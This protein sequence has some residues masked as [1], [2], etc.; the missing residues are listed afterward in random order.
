MQA[1]N[2]QFSV[3]KGLPFPE[4]K[5]AVWEKIKDLPYPTKRITASDDRVM[6]MLESLAD[7]RPMI[8]KRKFRVNLVVKKT[9]YFDEFYGRQWD[10]MVMVSEKGAYDKYNVVADMFNELPRIKS[11]GIAAPFSSFEAWSNQEYSTVWIQR[12]HTD[13]ITS[14]SAHILREYLYESVPEPRQGYPSDYV[15]LYSLTQGPILD[16][17]SAYGDRMIVAL[18]KR[19][20]YV[21]IDPWKDLFRGYADILKFTEK[22]YPSSREGIEMIRGCSENFI[23]RSKQFG[24]VISSP[25]PYDV[26]PYGM[27]SEENREGQSYETYPDLVSW[28]VN[29][30][31]ATIETAYLCLKEGGVY[32]ATLL[33][34]IKGKSRQG[35]SEDFKEIIYTELFLLICSA[36]G[37]RYKG[38][39]GHEGGQGSITPWW[40]FQRGELDT[41]E[42]RRAINSIQ[43]HY[44]LVYERIIPRL[45]VYLGSPVLIPVREN[46]YEG[47]DMSF[48]FLV[49]DLPPFYRSPA[50]EF[51]RAEVMDMVLHSIS[52]TLRQVADIPRDKIV[53]YTSD[54]I[55]AQRLAVD[56]LFPFSGNFID[57]FVGS[58]SW[59]T[60]ISPE[61]Y[62]DILTSGR[63]I[64]GGRAFKGVPALM[65]AGISLASKFACRP[66][67]VTYSISEEGNISTITFNKE[68]TEPRKITLAT[69]ALDRLRSRYKGGSFDLDASI[70]LLRYASLG[71]TTHNFTRDSLR[72]EEL[73]KIT[74]CDFEPFASPFNA[75]SRF[76]CS[77]F[78]DTDAP[79]GSQG[80]FFSGELISGVYSINPANDPEI[81]KLA[82]ERSIKLVEEA[83]KEEE[84]LMLLV[85]TVTY[86]KKE[87]YQGDAI[88]DI[89]HWYR[90]NGVNGE[91]RRMMD[92]PLARGA[93]VLSNKKFRTIDPLSLQSFE[94]PLVSI[95]TVLSSKPV[96]MEKFSP[97]RAER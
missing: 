91:I 8:K 9:D 80:N 29:Y 20:K 37:F 19:R 17:S 62:K 11:K 30:H 86:P 58:L 34:R 63:F 56:P 94:S 27:Y 54:Y 22:R 73:K 6:S 42:M 77:V 44:P 31:L 46:S 35:D 85:G 16:M 5:L 50:Y 53:E 38:M 64:L 3:Q 15:S 87:K 93:Y 68:G 89:F 26:E 33:D 40:I 23:P 59:L 92:H 79:F 36:V 7:L 69:E 66:A 13:G 84:D 71:E 83:E 12:M 61:K 24:L 39:L 10:D 67:N 96:D 60:K 74:G 47:E 25:A 82:V 43:E 28:M 81:V 2:Y 14:F 45:S 48:R 90:K 75:F 76:F 88:H 55:M 78:P 97:M 1:S 65:R 41:G 95:V 70:M 32:A 57:P 4:Y 72:Y 52:V 51:A 21:G 18:V 49:P